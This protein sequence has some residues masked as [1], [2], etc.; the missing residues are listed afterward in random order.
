MEHR[1]ADF[2]IMLATDSYK[3]PY[4]ERLRVAADREEGSDGLVDGN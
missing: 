3:V 4:R 1:G 2:N